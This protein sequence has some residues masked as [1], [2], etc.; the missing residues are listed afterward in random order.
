[1]KALRQ[2]A[3]TRWREALVPMALAIAAV[4]LWTA[5]C[6]RDD[7]APV[8][9]PSSASP[10]ED[11]SKVFGAIQQSGIVHN[12]A[13]NAGHDAVGIRVVDVQIGGA[14]EIE[15]HVEGDV[16]PPSALDYELSPMQ[17]SVVLADDDPEMTEEPPSWIDRRSFYYL[18]GMYEQVE[19]QTRLVG[20]WI[21][22]WNYFDGQT[23]TADLDPGTVVLEFLD[24]ERY[25]TC[26]WY[27][28]SEW[29]GTGGLWGTAIG[30]H[31]DP[32]VRRLRCIHV[33]A[34][35]FEDEQFI[36]YIDRTFTENWDS[37]GNHSDLVF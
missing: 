26:D 10:T 33:F 37:D 17:G 2:F 32:N 16:E 19:G 24:G 8:T 14:G 1:M 7:P 6:D 13:Q 22:M 36:R 35:Y 25:C 23:H 11:A 34:D 20:L 15:G 28:R 30:Y 31:W 29:S 21:N 5:G 27:L 4:A 18:S 9:A 3:G 12:G